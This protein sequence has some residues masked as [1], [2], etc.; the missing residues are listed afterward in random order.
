ML[1]MHTFMPFLMVL[2]DIESPHR[3]MDL[4]CG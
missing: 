2:I 1:Q 4:K 3:I